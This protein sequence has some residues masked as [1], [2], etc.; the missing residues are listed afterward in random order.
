MPL[1]FTLKNMSECSE[2]PHINSGEAAKELIPTKRKPVFSITD[3]IDNVTNLEDLSILVEC[4]KLLAMIHYL[5]R[6]I[7]EKY[8]KYLLRR[9]RI[10]QMWTEYFRNISS[11]RP[12]ISEIFSLEDQKLL[13]YKGDLPREVAVHTG[14]TVLYR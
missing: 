4:L 5:K 7:G 2:S 6:L 12:N 14:P 9:D 10:L 11:P 3:K 1:E 13:Y 8:K